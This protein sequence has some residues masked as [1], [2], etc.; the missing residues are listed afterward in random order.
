MPKEI[1]E[2]AATSANFVDLFLVTLGLFIT[3]TLC[4]RLR[5][6]ISWMFWWICYL[7]IAVIAVAIGLAILYPEGFILA[8]N[9]TNQHKHHLEE[10]QVLGLGRNILYDLAKNL[11]RSYHIARGLPV[12]VSNP[13]P[14]SISLMKTTKTNP[15]QQQS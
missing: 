9:Y 10:S 7:G 15:A 12:I 6:L 13:P 5:G 8:R 1:V 2:V 14:S 4:W 11:Y 3:F